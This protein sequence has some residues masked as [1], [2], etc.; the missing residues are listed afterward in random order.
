MTVQ[1]NIFL[2]RNTGFRRTNGIAFQNMNLRLDDIDARHFF[3]D[4]VLHLN[5]RINFDEVKRAGIS[6]HQEFDRTCTD[7]IG[8]MSDLQAVACQFLTLCII[9]IRRW[10]TF[11]HFLVTALDRAIALIKMNRVA[12]RITQNLH[13]N[14]TRTLDKLFEIDFILAERSF[15]FA[16]GFRHFSVKVFLSANGTHTATAA[17]P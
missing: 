6:I 15:S 12:M 2:F 17:A 9:E 14:V 3:R 8:G 4:G 10:R 7:I 13:F 11:N 1:A 16:L 5:T